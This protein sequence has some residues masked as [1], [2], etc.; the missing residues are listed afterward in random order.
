[1]RL[2]A[3]YSNGTSCLFIQV[4]SYQ[5][6]PSIQVEKTAAPVETFAVNDTTVYLLENINNNSAVWVTEHYECLI[7]GAVAK[8]EL[9]QMVLSA[10]TN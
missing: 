6:K 10:Y 9:Q 4:K 5:D 8:I 3:E 7:G 2:M 1:M